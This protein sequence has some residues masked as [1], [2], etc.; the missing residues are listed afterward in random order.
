[1]PL[2]GGV[3]DFKLYFWHIKSEISFRSYEINT[4]YGKKYS[5]ESS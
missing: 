2:W 1:M 3:N 5:Y 4:I